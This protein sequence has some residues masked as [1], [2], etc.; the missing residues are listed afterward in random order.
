[1]IRYQKI[2]LLAPLP[3]LAATDPIEEFNTRLTA[4]E[5][6]LKT[7]TLYNAPA[8][9]QV[10]DPYHIF[11]TGDF[12]Y[13]K[14]EENGLTYA[15][16]V[17]SPASAE[18]SGSIELIDPHFRWDCGFRLGMGFDLPHDYW[19]LYFNW[20]RFYTGA[21][22]HC[23][24]NAV[25]GIF[26]VYAFP[27]GPLQNAFVPHSKAFW[28]LFLNI[29]DSELGK[30]YYVGKR[31]SLRPHLDLRTAFIDQEFTVDYE[32]PPKA[33][34]DRVKLKNDYWGVGPRTGLDFQ[35]WITDGLSFS[36]NVAVSLV[37][38]NF[39]IH[40][41]EELEGSSTPSLHF[42]KHLHTARAIT[43]LGLYIGWDHMCFHDTFHFGIRAGWE[44]HVFFEQNQFFRFVDPYFQGSI[45][46]NQGNLMLQGWTFS[47]RLDF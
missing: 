44:Q 38:G 30:E 1:M 13:W 23:N 43:D 2:L 3:L 47:A 29:L 4:V 25:Q 22:G 15:L 37:Y 27:S 21:H 5:H 31:L 7:Q 35:W 12:L 28:K 24:T 33:F 14:A 16:K 34:F 8:L 46:S 19:D 40:Q 10:H 26:P 6:Q 36:G 18:L 42:H 20:T 32:N 9:P 45:V 17:E 11:F 39:S 41:K